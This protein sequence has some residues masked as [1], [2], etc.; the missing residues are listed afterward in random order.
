MSVEESIV[1]FGPIDQVGWASAS[2]LVTPASSSRR[3]PRNGP[4]LA[5]STI[6]VSSRPGATDDRRH[7]CTA[8]CS[9]STGISSAPGVARSGCTTGPAAIRLSLLAR[10]SRLPA[11]S[12]ATVTGSPAKPTTPLTTTSA[13]S[14]RP[15]RSSTTWANGSASATSARGRRIGDGDHLRPVLEGLRDQGRRRG[16]DAQADHLVAVTLGADDVEGLGADRARRAGDGDPHRHAC[17]LP[18]RASRCR[19]AEADGREGDGP[20]AGVAT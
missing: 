12:V 8:Q 7:W 18:G 11:A 10:A 13:S 5:V 1:I 3:R 20:A 16:A 14:T 15:A 19:P 9:E 17:S 6:R 4:P 2:S